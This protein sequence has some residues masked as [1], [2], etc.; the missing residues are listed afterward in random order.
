[1]KTKVT[2][3]ATHRLMPLLEPCSIAI[4]GASGRSGRPGYHTVRAVRALGF[5]GAVYP[6]TPSYEQIDGLECYAALADLP[7]PVD[8]VIVAGASARLETHIGDALRHGARSILAYANLNVLI[9]DDPKVGERLR[10]RVREAQVPLAGPYSIGYVNLSKTRA[11]AWLEPDPKLLRRGGIATIVH[12]GATYSYTMISE[13]R[14]G[15]TLNVHPGQE[16]DLTVADYMDYALSCPETRVIGLFLEA[17]RDPVGFRAALERADQAGVPVV[18]LHVGRTEAGARHVLSHS[19]RLAGSTSALDAVF[20]HHGVFR[21]D[22]MEEWWASLLLFDTEPRPSAGDVV[23]MA[24]SGGQRALIADHAAKIGLPWTQITK[25]TRDRLTETLDPTLNPEN[26]LDFWGGEPDWPARCE[27]QLRA[28]TSDP[29]AGIGVVFTDFTVTDTDPLPL[30]L[31]KICRKV[32]G[33]SAVPVIAAQYTAR[34]FHPEA[35]YLLTEAG[36][37]VLDG[38]RDALLAIKNALD[39]R[40][41]QAAGRAQ[42]P[43]RL[44]KP[45]RAKVGDILRRTTTLD[46]VAALDILGELGMPVIAHGVAETLKETLEV[47]DNIGY[48]VALKTAEPGIVHKSDCQGVCLG[49]MDTAELQ[50]QYQEMGKRLGPRVTV[51][52]MAGSG[53]ELSLGMVRDSQFGPL[54]MLGS[55]GVMVEVAGDVIFA[56]PPFNEQQGLS[57]LTSLAIAPRLQG[58]RGEPPVDL[59]GLGKVISRFS[60]IAAGL[61]NDI[62]EIDINPL[63]AGPWG[64]VAVDALLVTAN[65]MGEQK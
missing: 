24:D 26:P 36:I 23:A 61:D 32:A 20:R 18:V 56:L 6:V 48:P 19:G 28:L 25:K 4:V 63:I 12:S 43:Q 35:I 39:F 30:A 51:A 21:V 3:E 5:E 44:S 17:I 13:P 65:E 50:S 33:E 60:V 11:A 54:V 42:T 59:P 58:A 8:L 41:R 2:P 1:M 9:H 53:V 37:P 45:D 47:A 49:V 46:E 38:S 14:A 31:A 57:L 40:D 27:Q 34:H 64:C 10:S 7:E 29:G 22:T 16:L 55:G 52:A 62:T 15:F